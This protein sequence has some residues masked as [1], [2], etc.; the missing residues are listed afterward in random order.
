MRV[1]AGAETLNWVSADGQGE[2]MHLQGKAVDQQKNTP[3]CG[4]FGVCAF[5]GRR[6]G[7]P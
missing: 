4:R 6:G 2:A 1:R 7:D 5:S 3:G